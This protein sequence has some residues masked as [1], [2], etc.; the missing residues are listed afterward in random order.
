MAQKPLI[1]FLLCFLGFVEQMH[2]CQR[3]AP[4]QRR[5]YLTRH[6]EAAAL[7]LGALLAAVQII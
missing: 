3:F 6:T 4:T 1:F 2:C 5:R 7:T